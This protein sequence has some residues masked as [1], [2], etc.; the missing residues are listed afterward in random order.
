MTN[1]GH[2][3]N[4]T[5]S[6]LWARTFLNPLLNN[7]YFMDGTLVLLTFDESETY[8]LKNNIFA[9]LLGGAIPANLRGTTDGTFYNH[10]STI[11]TVSAN[12]GLPSLGRWDCNANV[13]ALVANKTGYANANVNV[14]NLYYNQSY[15]GPLSDT[16]Y[17]ASWPVPDIN[18]TCANG[19]GVLPAVKKA[20]AGLN[21]TYN[22]TVN[23]A[24]G[25]N[26]ASGGASSSSS[27]GFAAPTL[28]PQVGSALVG[29]LAL[30]AAMVL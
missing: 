15:P 12:W 17:K 14:T 21:S 5:F 18:A 16:A 22:Y 27:A 30:G 25:F 6:S 23:P 24:S 9:V 7:S 4:V 8:T 10:Y 2:D 19:K 13:F 1:D 20:W 29:V 28:A 26:V 11:S 3:T